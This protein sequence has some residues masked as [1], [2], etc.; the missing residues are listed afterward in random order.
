MGG[1]AAAAAFENLIVGPLQ[2]DVLRRTWLPERFNCDGTDAHN[3]FYFEYASVTAMLIYEVR[4]GISLR[5]T[6][7][8]VDPLSAT[9]F[10]LALGGVHIG[11]HAN[12][13]FHATLPQGASGARAFRVTRVAPGAW[14]VTV[15]G[16]PPQHA[17]VG[18]DGVLAFDVSDVAAGPVDAVK[19][20]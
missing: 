14:T 18:A 7:I 12:A 16:V 1:P 13:T 5:L 9:D 10:D 4:Y 20:N 15:G 3:S 17:T 19:S 8:T 2:A 6:S 11:Y